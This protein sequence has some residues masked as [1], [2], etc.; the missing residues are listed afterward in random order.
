LGEAPSFYYR[1]TWSPDSKRIAYTDKRKII[2]YLDLQ[3]GRSTKVDTDP[4]PLGGSPSL[5]WSPD[6]KWIVYT[7][8]L[9]RGMAA[10]FL[11][12]LET[13][14]THQITDGMSDVQSTDFDKGGKYL[15][16]TASTDNGPIAFG[17]M[18]A[19]NRAQTSSVYLVVLNKNDP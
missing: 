4:I 6:S 19:F 13:G 7:R 9:K 16:F 8:N 14:K 17:S 11:Y 12:S 2:W 3:S 15:Y 10:V 5:A 18:S 1:P